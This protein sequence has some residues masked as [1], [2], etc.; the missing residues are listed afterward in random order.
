M[1]KYYEFKADT[2]YCGTEAYEYECF[3][4]PTEED[5]EEYAYELRE[6]NADSYEYLVHGW[7]GECPDEEEDPEGYQEYWEEIEFYRDGCYCYYR[8][9]TREEFLENGGVES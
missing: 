9:I 1:K 8:E 5:L 7:D 2:P 3:E 4:D 6:N